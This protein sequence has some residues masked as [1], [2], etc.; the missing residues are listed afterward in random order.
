VYQSSFQHDKCQVGDM[1]TYCRDLVPLGGSYHF[2]LDQRTIIGGGG[3]GIHSMTISL[4][5]SELS[6]YLPITV[7]EPVFMAIFPVGVPVSLGAG[8]K[9]RVVRPVSN[10]LSERIVGDRFPEGAKL[11][12]QCSETSGPACC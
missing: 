5:S 7:H 11:Q 10:S 12:L 2:S 9:R 4:Q 8:L 6:S 3:G 1:H